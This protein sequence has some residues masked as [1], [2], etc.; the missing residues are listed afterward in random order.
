MRIDNLWMLKQKTTVSCPGWPG[1]MILAYGN[2]NSASFDPGAVK[3]WRIADKSRLGLRDM[4][5]I[6]RI[7]S[8]GWPFVQFVAI[9]WA[10]HDGKP[11]VSA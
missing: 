9:R 4:H 3:K 1:R 10:C 11:R 5:S 6:P 8:P 2:A 7:M